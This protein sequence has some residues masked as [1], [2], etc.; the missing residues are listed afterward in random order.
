[1]KPF[2]SVLF[3]SPLDILG[4]R[5]KD[6]VGWW[7]LANPA[8]DTAIKQRSAEPIVTRSFIGCGFKIPL[9]GPPA[10]QSVRLAVGVFH[11]FDFGKK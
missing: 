5:A 8:L 2:R 10:G 6:S 4:K 1:M 7:N 3:S 11:L 9:V